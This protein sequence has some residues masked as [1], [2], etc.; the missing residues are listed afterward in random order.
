M[1]NK[2][3][4]PD[5][6][7]WFYVIQLSYN[8]VWGFGITANVER[9]LRKGYC[10]PTATIQKFCHLYYGKRS[11]IVGLERHLKSEWADKRMVLFDEKLEWFSQES[12]IDGQKIIDFVESRAKA[13][14]PDIYR[15][16]AKHLPF[17]P[18]NYFYDIKDYPN[19]Y[20]E[21]I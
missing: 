6:C 20:L 13:V 7:S 4:L 16:K 19:N 8:G 3:V 11:Q 17:S 1:R 15:V 12:G 21:V 18:S 9:R 14:Y 5:V 2:I 10:N